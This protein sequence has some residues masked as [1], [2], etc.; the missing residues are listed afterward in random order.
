M[1]PIKLIISAFGPYAG[2]TPE[3]NFEQFEDRGL[4]LIAGDTGAGKTTIFDAICFALYGQTSGS[5]KDAKYLRS[6]Y[7]KEDTESYVDFYFSHQGRNYHV[8]R[9]PAYE[10]PSRRGGGTVEI[11]ENALLEGD[12]MD[13]VEGITK[14]NTAVQELLKISFAQFKQIVMIAQGEFWSLLNA[15]TDQRTEI[16]RTIFETKGYQNIE[17]GLKR[18]MDEA[19]GR[20]HE[21]ENTIKH[22]FNDVQVEKE[23]EL[24]ENIA[25]LRDPKGKT[26][27]A[28]ALLD[29]LLQSLDQVIEAET[30]KKAAID[31]ERKAAN[32][33]LEKEKRVLATAKTNNGFIDELERL[34]NEK[35]RLD[36]LKPE[37]EEKQL[38]LGRQQAASRVAG[39]VVNTWKEREKDRISGEKQIND[40]EQALTAAEE[41]QKTAL[42]AFEEADKKRPEG[43]ALTKKAEKIESD[44]PVYEQKQRLSGEL[45]MLQETKKEME[46]RKTASAEKIKKLNE[47][48]AALR[49]IREALKDKPSEQISTDAELK[50]ITALM[51]NL[52][53]IKGD[54][55]KRKNM[56]AEVQQKQQIFTE[57]R[58]KYEVKD[59]K[60]KAAET[61]LE[62]NR[63]GLLALTLKE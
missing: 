25:L 20:Q 22:Y 11:K 13:S 45:G 3:I 32:E 36:S 48:I 37:I 1:K 60:R 2:T 42:Q 16:L 39:P 61:A 29:Q 52:D 30:E 62:N 55:L 26:Q 31:A 51:G 21:L 17:F 44:K 28:D 8:R 5:F 4:F 40:A 50:R 27:L 35:A 10:R 57:I 14:V 58:A 12:G 34:K 41:A 54:I 19:G 53:P 56:A 33:D 46:Q 23:E 63:A 6:E 49:D 59:Q 47:R 38:L 18:R 43:E 24:P 15:K 9:N 7:A